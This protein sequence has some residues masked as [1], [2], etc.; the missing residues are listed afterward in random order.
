MPETKGA[1]TTVATTTPAPSTQEKKSTGLSIRRFFT[2]A[3]VAPYYKVEWELRTAR[4]TD[5]KGNVDLRAEKRRSP[6]RLVDDRHQHRGHQI[7]ARHA[8]H[9]RARNRSAPA[10]LPR[11]RDHPR[12][13]LPAAT[14]AP[15]K[16][17]PF[18]TTSSC[19]SWSASTRLQLARLVQRRLPP[20]RARLRR[21]N[22]HWNPQ[23]PDRRLRR[24]RI[25]QSA[26]LRLLH[27][28][29]QRHHR[30]HPHSRQDRRHALQ[31]GIRHRH[32]SLA[33]ALLH[34]KLSAA[35]APPPA[36]SAS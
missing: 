6:Q 21:P 9:S 1:P 3:G 7:S 8:R 19:T 22:W 35:A 13:G 36:R 11:R 4:I 30:L 32:Q 5:A 14:S 15:P 20:P 29:D 24:H 28:L 31:V 17:A 27:Q 12:L 10:G 18:S 16:T 33:S 25:Q 34:R 26:V 2:K 23:D